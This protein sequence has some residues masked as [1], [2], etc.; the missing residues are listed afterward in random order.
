MISYDDSWRWLPAFADL[1][2][3]MAV[4]DNKDITEPEFAAM[5]D[6][7]GFKDLTTYKENLNKQFRQ[8]PATVKKTG[9]RNNGRR[10]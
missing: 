1:F 7:C 10:K 9:K 8:A 6:S 4:V 2:K 3:K 5:L